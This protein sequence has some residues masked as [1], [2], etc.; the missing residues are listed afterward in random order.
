MDNKDINKELVIPVMH[1]FNDNYAI[2]T[3]QHEQDTVNIICL[4]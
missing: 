1:C 2:P 3:K 4:I